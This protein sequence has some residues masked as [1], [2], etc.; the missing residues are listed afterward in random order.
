[1]TAPRE[2]LRMSRRPRRSSANHPLGLD[3]CYCAVGRRSYLG[4]NCHSS[5]LTVPVRSRQ[6]RLGG[7][8][9]QCGLVRC[10][11]G[12]W[13][14]RQND[15]LSKQE[16]WQ[17]PSSEARRQ[18]RE[19]SQACRTARWGTRPDRARCRISASPRGDAVRVRA[20]DGL[21][22][23]ARFALVAGNCQRQSRAVSCRRR[24]VLAKVP[25]R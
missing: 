6:I 5:A 15:H 16:G 25:G 9:G 22:C 11:C 2:A 13:N 18:G 8:S 24:T 19:G 23:R 20:S 14:D 3:S 21:P 4:D 7:D 1:M 10:R 17:H 12:L